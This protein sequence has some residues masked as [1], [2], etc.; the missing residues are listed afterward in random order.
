[1]SN[2]TGAPVAK[3]R[4][5]SKRKSMAFRMGTATPLLKRSASTYHEKRVAFEAHKR[6]IHGLTIN[7][8][9]VDHGGRN[10]IPVAT[11]ISKTEDTMAVTFRGDGL[12]N[13]GWDLDDNGKFAARTP[14]APKTNAER[15]KA[16]KRPTIKSEAKATFRPRAF[17]C[18]K[19]GMATGSYLRG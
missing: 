9:V 17:G 13:E 2:K 15:A 11:Y 14:P 5:L 19:Y 8:K 12:P 1:M 16:D 10:P 6:A 18:K 4:E 7:D 3:L